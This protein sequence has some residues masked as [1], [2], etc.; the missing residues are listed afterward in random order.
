MTYRKK[1]NALR[2]RMCSVC[3]R[4]AAEKVKRC[5]TPAG[6]LPD[7]TSRLS[8]C[9]GQIER[10]RRVERAHSS[11]MHVKPKWILPTATKRRNA[12]RALASAL[13]RAGW[14]AEQPLMAGTF[15]CSVHVCYP[16]VAPFVYFVLCSLSPQLHAG[17]LAMPTIVLC[18]RAAAP[19]LLCFP[20]VLRFVCQVRRSSQM[21][22][23]RMDGAGGRFCSC[24]LVSD[25]APSALSCRDSCPKKRNGGGTTKSR[26]GQEKPSEPEDSTGDRRW[27]SNQRGGVLISG[28]RF[29]KTSKLVV[30]C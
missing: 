11:D 3:A 20:L 26:H 14:A 4:K 16:F 24:F 8:F 30:C 15:L 22:R 28:R 21:G 23:W 13:E 17:D 27:P 19:R 5:W 10:T 7:R 18:E 29:V 9:R 25:R 6:K 1:V 2:T 12:Q